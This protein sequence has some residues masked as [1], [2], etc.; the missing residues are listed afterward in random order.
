MRKI[1]ALSMALCLAFMLLVGGQA[2]FADKSVG[3]P[4]EIRLKIGAEAITINGQVVKV[5]KPYVDK[6][7]T[8]VPL[9]VIT[10]AFGAELKL[11]KQTI[12]LKYDGH[13][14]KLVFDKPEVSVDGISSKLLAAPKVVGGVTMVPL[15]FISEKFGG[16]VGNDAS[17]G[18]IIITAT[19]ADTGGGNSSNGGNINVDAGKTK[20]GDS[21]YK[22][23]MKYPS[24]LVQDY[25]NPA[26]N[27][28]G[29][30]DAKD[31]FL[32]YVYMKDQAEPLSKEALLKTLVNDLEEEEETVVDKKIVDNGTTP[33]AKAISKYPDGGFTET[34]TY[35][36]NNYYYTVKF[37]DKK[38]KNYKDLDKHKDLLDSF[39]TSFDGSDRALKDLS[40]VVDGFRKVT[41][42][43]YGITLNVP[44]N[45]LINKDDLIFGKG[46]QYM[47]LKISSIVDGDRVDKWAGREEK[48]FTEMFA[49]GFR[50][51][52]ETKQATV[53]STSATVRKLEY[54][55]GARWWSEYDAFLFKGKF[56]VYVEFGYP[57]D[58]SATAEPLHDKMI[59]SIT[60]DSAKMEESFGTIE[61]ENDFV[62]KTK[63]ITKS[64][65]KNKY[66]VQV[67]EFWNAESVDMDEETATIEFQGGYVS[68]N[69]VLNTVSSYKE[70]LEELQSDYRESEKKDPNFKIV[71][72]KDETYFGVAG[73]KI[74]LKGKEDGIAYQAIQYLFDKNGFSYLVT[75]KMNDSVHTDANFKRMNDVFAS[76]KLT[77]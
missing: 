40:N 22:W 1:F 43:D 23:S 11:E 51:V 56:K 17:T 25:V 47:K 52:L 21:Y 54:T 77:E 70:T 2:A 44:A 18:E 24:G 64:S 36:S 73:K 67:P 42:E 55:N 72:L 19:L 75:L 66:S 46:D 39:K 48:L 10:R 29:Y 7:V 62:D 65:K 26:N 63:T 41:L 74:V 6:G 76:M 53:A 61:D 37:I 59:G 3:K 32:M 45:W 71:E 30:A 34:R 49:D 14:I 28:V 8:M 20:V 13:T 5:Q 50:N 27:F 58:E 68:V 15:R 35:Y 31:E 69:A 33:Y 38:A 57:K 60:I 12:I 9:S 4:L 16:T